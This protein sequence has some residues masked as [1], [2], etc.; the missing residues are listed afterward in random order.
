MKSD[1]AIIIF[2]GSLLPSIFPAKPFNFV[3]QL[4]DYLGDLQRFKTI[5]LGVAEGTSLRIF[6]EFANCLST[7]AGESRRLMGDPANS[8]Y[9]GISE[10]RTLPNLDLRGFVRRAE[11]AVNIAEIPVDTWEEYL[12]TRKL[13]FTYKFGAIP[14]E[15]HRVALESL[16]RFVSDKQQAVQAINQGLR[17]SFTAREI[18]GHSGSPA[19]TPFDQVSEALAARFISER[20]VELSSYMPGIALTDMT[21][22]MATEE[23]IKVREYRRSLATNTH[24][25]LDLLQRAEQRHQEIVLDCANWLRRNRITPLMS[26]SFDLAFQIDSGLAVVE[27]KSAT[28]SNFA[29]QFEKGLMQ[30][31]RY[32]WQASSHVS[33]VVSKLVIELPPEYRGATMSEFCE[34]SEHL[35]ISLA[36][37][38]PSK[39]WPERTPHL[40]EIPSLWIPPIDDT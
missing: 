26:N 10:H 37:W 25:S 30:S 31:L 17:A 29:S 14:P 23:N 3:I 13:A 4:P 18:H 12:Q 20:S 34:F 36:F 22:T 5:L 2:D 32:R 21:L 38:D 39:E 7:V 9:F 8:F 40:C 27:V 19:S 35:G 28:E 33:R 6:A 24:E 11:F 16:P 15:V 1:K